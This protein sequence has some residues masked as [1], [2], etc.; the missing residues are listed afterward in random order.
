MNKIYIFQRVFIN[1][2]IVLNK[3]NITTFISK[4]L[5]YYKNINIKNEKKNYILFEHDFTNYI[6]DF[7]NNTQSLYNFIYFLFEKKFKMFKTYIN[8]HLMINFIKYF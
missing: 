7:I 2:I 3:K 8:K 4:C 1:N 6:I 5:K